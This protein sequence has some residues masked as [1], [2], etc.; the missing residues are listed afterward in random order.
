MT[1][2][3]A[4]EVSRIAKEIYTAGSWP[5]RMMIHA[6]PYICPFEEL[7]AKVPKGATVLDVGCGDGLFL[8]TLSYIRKLSTG[9]GF[10]TNSVAIASAQLANRNTS[11]IIE[12]NFMEWSIEEPWPDGL[13]DVVSMIDVLHHIPP[14]DKK[15]AIQ[16]AADHVKP[17]GLLILKDIGHKPKWRA[18]FN[19]LHD[20]VLT[21]EHV[22][23]TK[24]D[25]VAA[26]VK[27]SGLIEIE[28]RTINRFWYGH[29]MILFLK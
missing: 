14:P 15:K 27:T 2:I 20:Y 7:I 19:S 1:E 26:W 10:D 4:R 5:R 16:E 22:T 18:F 11:N 24:L 13:F 3:T 28:R 6:R 29:E 17:G 21:G 23:Y 25:C 8:N 12:L 9:I